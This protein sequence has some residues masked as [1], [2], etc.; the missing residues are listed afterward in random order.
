MESNYQTCIKCDNKKEEYVTRA[1]PVPF[2][3]EE[4][5]LT[6][7]DTVHIRTQDNTNYTWYITGAISEVANDGTFYYWP[8]KPKFKDAFAEKGGSGKYVQFLPN[9]DVIQK[10]NKDVYYWPANPVTQVIEGSIIFE[11][12]YT[13]P[14]PICGYEYDGIE[15]TCTHCSKDALKDYFRYQG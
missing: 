3:F 15:D 4:E 8:A 10:Q 11:P 14:C 6:K 9:G 2:K 7:N 5:R 13:C 12:N 1:L